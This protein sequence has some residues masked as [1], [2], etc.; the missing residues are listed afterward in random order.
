[1]ENVEMYTQECG[2]NLLAN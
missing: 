2:Q 1:M